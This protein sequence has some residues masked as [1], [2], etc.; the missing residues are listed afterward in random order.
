MTVSIM[1]G[2]HTVDKRV[3]VMG[4]SGLVGSALMNVLWNKPNH[5][6]VGTC[7]SNAKDGLLSLEMDQ[8]KSIEEVIRKVK[9]ND[10]YI[11]S[12]ISNVDRC[13]TDGY[14]RKVNVDGV[15]KIVVE[16]K[17]INAR[18]VFF[19]SSYVFDG[20]KSSPYTV[21]DTPQP[22]Q[23]YGIQKMIGEEFVLSS[24]KRNVVVRTIGVFGPEDKRHNFAYHVIDHILQKQEVRASTTQLMNPIHSESLAAATVQM[25]SDGF[26]GLLHIG[27]S[28]VISR[29]EW[30]YDIALRFGLNAE[31]VIPNGKLPVMDI[32]PVNGSLK[33]NISFDTDYN[34]EL[35]RFYESQ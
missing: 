1:I 22:I 18:V 16:A 7:Y 20:K 19:S 17:K 23:Q 21:W 28:E 31:L 15:K 10:I 27:G 34:A 6:I 26:A 25:V 3:L 9:P 24:D 5:D 30:G 33:N 14:T 32:R 35:D 12:Y 13:E 2:V 11:A 8:P 4:A 29:Y